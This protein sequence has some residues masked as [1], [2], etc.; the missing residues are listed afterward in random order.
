LIHFS[1]FSHGRKG[2]DLSL[3]FRFAN[4]PNNAKLEMVKAA[5][6]RSQSQGEVMIALQLEHGERLQ[7]T[8]QP[9]ATLWEVLQQFETSNT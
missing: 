3:A 9:G 1:G 2:L 6:P 4:L 8:F 7:Q 5:T